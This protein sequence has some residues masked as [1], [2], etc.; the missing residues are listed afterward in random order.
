M[1]VIDQGF[2]WGNLQAVA[3]FGHG[4][5]QL[6]KPDTQVSLELP[7]RFT[8]VLE[9]RS[10][11]YWVECFCASITNGTFDAADKGELVH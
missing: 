9:M 7:Y 3:A 1:A 11:P 8:S 6:K 10:V 5:R 4:I 2:G